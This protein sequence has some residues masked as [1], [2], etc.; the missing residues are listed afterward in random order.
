MRYISISL[1]A[2]LFLLGS[3]VN[4][5]FVVAGDW[6]AYR[7]DGR[8]SGVTTEELKI[9]LS[10]EWTFTATHPPSHAWGDP[11]EQTVERIL[12][13]PRI[14]F[15]DAFQVAAAGGLIY[16]GSSSDNK[17]YA[18]DGETGAIR[19]EFYTEGPVRLAPAVWKGK[20]YAGSDDGKVYCLDAGDGRL[21]WTFSAAPDPRRVLGN[22]KMISIWP[23][24]TGVLVEDGVAHFGAG[25]FPAEGLYLYAV[26]AEDGKLIWKNDTYGDGGNASISPQGYLFA[27]EERLFVPSCRAMPVA[28]SRKDGRYLF[29]RNFSWRD[30]GLF[31]GTYNLLVEDLLLSGTEQVLGVSEKNGGL[32]FT[33]GLP[34]IVPTKGARRMSMDQGVLFLLTGKEAQAVDWKDWI[35]SRKLDRLSKLLNDLKEQFKSNKSIL[36]YADRVKRELDDVM[37]EQKKI[38]DPILW[39]IDCIAS[40]SLAVTAGTVFAGGPDL[41]LGLDRKTGKQVWSARVNGRA[42]GLAIAGGRL[43][44]ST[45]QGSI[46][47]FIPGTGGRNITVKPEIAAEPFSGENP[48]EFHK[49]LA[50]TILQESGVRRGYGMILGGDGRLALELA[51]RTELMIYL[52]ESDPK[53]VAE[54]RKALTA[55]G[56]YGG[57]VAVDRVSLES[58]PYSDYFANLIVCTERNPG[59]VPAGD[60]LRMLK[61]CGGV[62]FVGKPPDGEATDAPARFQDW[63]GQIRTNLEERGET[64]TK[65]SV[66]DNWAKISRGPLPGAGSWTHEYGEPGNSACSGDRLVR[67]PIGLLWF[68]EP[69]PGRMPNRHVS[70]A[71]PLAAGGRMFVQG[72]SVIMAYDAYNGLLL[73][74][75]ELPGA[76]RYYLKTNASNFAASEDSLLIAIGDQCYRMDM[77]TGKTLQTFRVPQ[78]ETVP[79]Q[80]KQQETPGKKKEEKKAPQWGY[81]ACADGLLFGSR[82]TDCVFAYEIES[83]KLRWAHAGKRIMATTICIGDGKVF[84]VDRSVTKEQE[85]QGLQGVQHE[86]KLDNRGKEIPPD[87]RLVVA[88]NA[89]TGKVVWEK[90]QYVSD[91]VE[92]SR[93]GGELS[94]LYAEDI[95]LLCGQPWNGHFWPEFFKGEFSRRSLIA[96]SSKDGYPLWSGK[97][98][99]RSRPLIVGNRIIAEPW[100]YD[101]RTGNELNRVH[102]VTG[103]DTKWQISRPG[104]HCGNIVASQSALFFRSGSAAYYDME[105]DYGT[106]HFSGQRPGCWINCI[107][108][109]GVVMMP[110]A[111][112]GCVCPYPIQ[113]TTVFQPRAE[114]R[115]WGMYSA[116]EPALPVKQLA[117][118]FG[119]PGDRKDG[120]GKLWLAYPRPYGGQNPEQRRLVIDL[121]LEAKL[122]DGGGY[123]DSN[124]DFLKLDGTDTPWIYASGCRGLTQCTIPVA[125]DDGTEGTYTVRLH[126]TEP[127]DLQPGQRV[128][129]VQIEGRTVVEKFDIVREAGGFERSLVKEIKGLQ[130]KDKLVISLK[131]H[132]GKPLICG[133]EIV[134]EGQRRAYKKL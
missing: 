52:A 127:E 102:P 132:R 121:P 4:P 97:K 85:K 13:L 126:F 7:H 98:G 110:E 114:N 67:G 118:N 108:A 51:R 47:C 33:E 80:E 25:V 100:S 74:E 26:N 43:L 73:W 79:P 83:G 53:R 129:D 24:R 60:I 89:Q 12:E 36:S 45:D 94:A 30:I 54:A 107:P 105:G 20:V 48:A 57:R 2:C 55:S 122:E 9:P 92:I 46:H 130:L 101:L 37:A 116:T 124:A 62:A 104:H 15:D 42:R 44:V 95:L 27:S 63:L 35:F 125:K 23:V 112:A 59:T 119:A 32:V 65:I 22:G 21:I 5:L 17:V 34:A 72:E 58:L 6:P 120:A 66:A 14:R 68:G 96:L 39:S 109:N 61:P 134:A 99:Y 56:L 50:E 82:D 128:F 84:L 1:F 8:R 49:N 81:V 78:D 106:A 11:P 19:W 123:F 69:G 117:V 88:I 133:L 41:V 86:K 91:C 113:C 64:G 3:L 77:E 71:A 18:L 70:A 31:G 10:P 38:H 75:R 28:F 16:F 29:H 76:K 131:A 111:S 103:G 40:D 115:M 93:G 87:V 90:P